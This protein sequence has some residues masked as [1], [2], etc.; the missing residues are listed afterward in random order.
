MCR[1]SSH[2]VDSEALSLSV[3]AAELPATIAVLPACASNLP[4]ASACNFIS[5]TPLQFNFIVHSANPH[6]TKSSS[7]NIQQ[8]LTAKPSNSASGPATRPSPSLDRLNT[9]T[10]C[11]AVNTTPSSLH[12][13]LALGGTLTAY[14]PFYI[15]RQRQFQATKASK[16]LSP[17]FCSETPRPLPSPR[18]TTLLTRSI[19]ISNPSY[20]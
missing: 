12:H 11:S 7:H 9:L 10:F 14:S 2:T 6:T 8:S 16:A 19:R 18:S 13:T 15:P 5:P 1:A 17:G 3:S 4:S 20:T